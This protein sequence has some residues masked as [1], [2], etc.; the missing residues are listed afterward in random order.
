MERSKL[1]LTPF[2]SCWSQEV[3]HPLAPLN[4]SGG[5]RTSCGVPMQFSFRVSLISWEVKKKEKKEKKPS[6]KHLKGKNVG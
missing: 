3:K 1:S 5:V 2:K 6:A 4:F